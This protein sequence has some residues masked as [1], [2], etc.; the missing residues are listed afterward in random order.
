MPHASYKT[1]IDA[2]YDRV[3]ELLIDKMEWPKKYVGVILHSTVLERGDG[4]ILREMYQP[5]PVDLTITE[6]IYQRDVP[7][8]QEFIYEHVDNVAYTGTFRNVVSRVPGR[9]DQV[10]LEYVMAWDPR[11]GKADKISDDQA[12]MS[13]R[14]GVN[15]IKDLAEHPAEVPDWVR[16]FF[17]VVDS[18]GAD[19]LGPLMADDVKFTMGN[20]PEVLGR[21]AVVA[22]SRGI[23]KMFKSLSHDYVSVHTAGRCTFVDS[24]VTYTMFDGSTFVLPFMTV[25]ERRGSEISSVKIFGDLSPLRFGWPA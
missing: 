20:G 4:F 17:D 5:K 16:A 18:M 24:W 9:D 6:K 12:K 2:S 14:N 21:E 23:T 11:P 8:G 7:G 1:T 22:G 10:E 13:V 3:S 19:A 25:F 15:H